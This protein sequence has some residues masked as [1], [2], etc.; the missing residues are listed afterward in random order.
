M[1]FFF[2]SKKMSNLIKHYQNDMK[3]IPQLTNNWGSMI[4]LL[5]KVLVEGFNFVPILSITKSSIE[6][7]T[8]TITLGAGHGFIDRQV[9]RIGG[10]TNGWDG[11]FKVLSANTDSVVIECLSSHPQAITGTASCSTA[12]LDFEIVFSTPSDSTEP[13]RAYRSTS[14]ESLGLIL[15]VHDFCVSGA[16]VNGAKF[17]KVG[18]V[19]AMSDIDNITG[20]QMPFDAQNSNANWGWDGARHGWAKWYYAV[21]TAASSARM[22]NDSTSPA[23]FNRSFT[24]V[25]SAKDGFAITNEICKQESLPMWVGYG[26]L[27]FYDQTLASNNQVL[28][29]FGASARYA[30]ATDFPLV[31]RGAIVA[32]GTSANTAAQT[33]GDL[34]GLLWFNSNGVVDLVQLKRPPYHDTSDYLFFSE[35]IVVDKSNNPR[36]ALP[37]F[38]TISQMK[39][40]VI[41]DSDFGKCATYYSHYDSNT[42]HTR[43][44]LLNEAK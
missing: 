37:F 32:F 25:G 41:Y 18:V 1:R 13:K 35:L 24:I 27:E 6:A 28:L 39:N 21:I 12:P 38:R 11:D 10:S 7:I 42:A 14:P 5:D 15:L 33:A 43:F 34:K 29:C 44:A 19:S 3:N 8:A 20:V 36:G 22:E 2:V 16:A 17:A 4:K 40:S 26:F 31:A 9:V 23:A 30:Q